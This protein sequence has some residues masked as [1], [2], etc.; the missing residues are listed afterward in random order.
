MRQIEPES[1]TANLAQTLAAFSSLH[2]HVAAIFLRDPAPRLFRFLYPR[3][4]VESGL[5]GVSSANWRVTLPTNAIF[6]G[7][8]FGIHPSVSTVLALSLS[9]HSRLTR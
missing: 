9:F 2:H 4:L 8:L 6:W 5:C 1:N 7:L 3:A